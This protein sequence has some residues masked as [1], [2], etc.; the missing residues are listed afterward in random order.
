MECFISYLGVLMLQWPKTRLCRPLQPQGSGRGAKGHRDPIFSHPD[1]CNKSWQKKCL[2]AK[3]KILVIIKRN[4]PWKQTLYLKADHRSVEGHLFRFKAAKPNLGYNLFHD[5][6]VRLPS[7]G[8]KCW[9]RA[10]FTHLSTVS[11]WK[12][13]MEGPPSHHCAQGGKIK[14]TSSLFEQT[15]N[16][17]P[18]VTLLSNKNQLSFSISYLG[19]CESVSFSKTSA[20]YSTT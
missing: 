15:T 12:Y 14:F 9:L 11:S 17:H 5:L 6:Y 7:A 4:L 20:L 2:R 10:D 1:P 13:Y 8:I 16:S 19:Y 3:T 18:F